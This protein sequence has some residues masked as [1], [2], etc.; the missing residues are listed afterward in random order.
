[1]SEI[2]RKEANVFLILDKEDE[3][4]IVNPADFAND[5]KLVYEVRG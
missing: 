2:V 5:K 1:M 4:Q 3:K